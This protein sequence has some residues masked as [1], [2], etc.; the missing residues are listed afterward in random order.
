MAVLES[1]FKGANHFQMAL[2]RTSTRQGM[3]TANLA[4]V[5]VPGYKRKDQDFHIML[6]GENDRLSQNMQQVR[7]QMAQRNSDQSSVRT[8]GNNVD[9]EKEVMSIAETEMHFQAVTDLTA[10]F[11]AGMKNVIREGK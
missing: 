5:N 11:F 7:D 4:N 2:G 8:D 6:A 9:L 3:L 10:G 1:L